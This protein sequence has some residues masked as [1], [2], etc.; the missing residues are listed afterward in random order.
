MATNT[1]KMLPIGCHGGLTAKGD[2]TLHL[3]AVVAVTSPAGH[4][5]HMFLCP[6]VTPR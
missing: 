6:E 2:R 1:R 4:S 5:G 3:G